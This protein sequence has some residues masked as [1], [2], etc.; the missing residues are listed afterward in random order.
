M[1]SSK[2]LKVPAVFT[3]TILFLLVVGPVAHGSPP[4]WPT[5]PAGFDELVAETVGRFGVAGAA[6]GVIDDGKVVLAKGYGMADCSA[7][8]PVTT[9]T[10]F[11]I[12][13]VSKMLAAWGVMRLVDQGIADLDAPIAESVKTWQLPSSSFD[14]SRVNVRRLL[15][16]TAGL[17]LHGYPGFG[18][19]EPLPTL[20]ESLSGATN[21]A[22]AVFLISQP[23]TNHRYSGGGYTLLQLMCEELT[24]KPFAQYMR[25]TV[26][27]PLAMDR[28]GFNREEDLEEGTARPHG[29]VR[30]PIPDRAFRAE[31]AAAAYTTLDDALRLVFAHFDMGPE[32]VPGRGVMSPDAVATLGTPVP[33][34]GGRW[35]HGPM[36][37]SEVDAEGDVDGDLV[38]GHGGDN[39]GWHALFAIHPPT[40]DGLV[41]MTNGDSGPALREYLQRPWSALVGIDPLLPA[42]RPPAAIAVLGTL[43]E[44][45]GG[46]AAEEYLR[47]QE[48]EP[49]SYNFSR[50]YFAW[51]GNGLLDSEFAEDALEFF[52]L[53]V[54]LFPEDPNIWVSLALAYQ[55][56]EDE[57][58]VRSSC[59]R[60]LE[61][62][63]RHAQAKELLATL[64]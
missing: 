57:D 10:R 47:M 26:F 48:E 7:Q 64:P 29:V 1:P 53:G 54:D 40:R 17:S 35:A 55:A 43:Q 33:D 9:D 36:V 61:L 32:A 11:N 24:G 39:P 46:A 41:V 49:D 62:N 5:T 14:R 51:V 58:G 2:Q 37:V 8:I 28:T 22:G 38:F 13:S 16:H 27:G 12:G 60:A 31:A 6:V 25:E 20:T 4:E 23:G 19:D 52:S 15:S 3:R 56:V 63:P 34:S 50:G 45:G 18:L 21:G 30:N 42:F 59:E 44:D